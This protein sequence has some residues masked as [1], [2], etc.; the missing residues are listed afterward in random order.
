MTSDP[1]SGSGLSLPAAQALGDIEPALL[2]DWLRTR[3]FDATIDISSSGVENYTLGDLRSLLDIGIEELDR[4]PFRDSPSLGC[5][6]LREAIAARYAPSR[7]DHVMATNGS[8]EAIFL[9]LAAI[10]RPGDEV[11]VLSPVYQSLSSIAAALGARLKLWELSAADDFAPDL[12]RLAALVT[13]RTRA[14]VVNFPHNPTGAM[15]D[16]AGYRRLLELVESAGCYLLWDAAL[17][18]LFY[19]RPTLPDPAGF[20]DRCVSFGTMSKAFGLPGLRIGWCVAPPEVLAA[21]VRL[22]DYVTLNTSPLNELL[23]TRVMERVEDVVGPWREQA[24]TN[25]ELLLG[26]AAAHPDL[27]SLPVPHGGVTGFP[28]FP[29]PDT[30][31][32]CDKLLTGHGVLMVPGVC[33]GHPDRV[34]LGFGGPTGELKAGLDAVAAVV[35]ELRDR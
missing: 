24:R 7:P 6:P 10:V 1:T 26:W 9:A 27:V 3:Y 18:E 11:V 31:V 25:R 14:V 12:D 17:G 16:E 32:L 33:F 23:A 5:D 19:E 35:A 13:P 30:V 4:L 15:P 28:A 21:M 20:M 2:E 34:R 29:L 22:R 8:T